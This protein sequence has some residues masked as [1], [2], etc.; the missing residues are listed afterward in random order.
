MGLLELTL[1][2]EMVVLVAATVELAV[3]EEL[4]QDVV[5]VFLEPV[6][7]LV[8]EIMV[9]PVEMVVLVLETEEIEE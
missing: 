1:A 9:V 6:L 2:G 3:L 5:L 7:D 4:Q 8:M